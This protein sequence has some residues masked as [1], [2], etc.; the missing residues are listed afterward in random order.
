VL[1]GKSVDLSTYLDLDRASACNNTPVLLLKILDP[2]PTE[3]LGDLYFE[4]H[5]EKREVYIVTHVDPKAWPNGHGG[6]RFG[7]NQVLRAKTT[8]EQFRSDFEAAVHAYEHIRRQ[9]DELGAQDIDTDLAEREQ[10]LR[11]RMN[12]YTQMR[13]LAV[14]D[15]VRVPTYTP[16]ALQHGVRVVEFQTQTYE[17][18][19][20]SFAQKVLT[21]DH[22]DSPE[23]IV[24]MHL[25]PP[26]K[27]IFEDVSAGVQR[28][29][30]FED[31]NV[32][33]VELSSES[34]TAPNEVRLPAALPYAVCM[35]IEGET[36]V[37]KLKLTAEQACFIPHGALSQTQICAGPQA[38]TTLLIAAPGL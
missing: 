30:R 31:F 11:A 14:G 26:P 27:E 22:W 6:I 7:M 25:D 3:V 17:R 18:L 23:A 1:E 8:D 20:I 34:G 4:L 28:I 21:Q 24:K 19:I 37:G 10:A 15:V 9:I 13:S 38:H 32:W 29:A 36:H 2:A 5:E 35:S 33:R 12:Q 16:H